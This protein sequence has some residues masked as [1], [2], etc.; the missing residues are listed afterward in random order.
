MNLKEF[1]KLYTNKDTNKNMII[2]DGVQL[3]LDTRK[4]RIFDNVLVIGGAGT[5]KTHNFIEPNILKGNCS[6]IIHDIEGSLYDET[7]DVLRSKGYDIQVLDFRKGMYNP[8][9]YIHSDEDVCDMI[10]CIMQNTNYMFK[11]NPFYYNL[12]VKFLSAIFF[13]LKETMSNNEESFESVFKIMNR[14]KDNYY[15]LIDTVNFMMEDLAKKNPNSLAVQ[16][17]HYFKAYC[18]MNNL[19][20]ILS[21][22][23]KR[24]SVFEYYRSELNNTQDIHLENIGNQ[25]TAIFVITPVCQDNPPVLTSLFFSQV[26][27]ELKHILFSKK[28]YEPFK[29]H[30]Q[31]MFDEFHNIGIIPKLLQKMN[32]VCWKHNVGYSFVIQ[33]LTQLQSM[34]EEDWEILIDY[35][36]NVLVFNPD[37][38]YLSYQSMI[39][40][41]TKKFPFETFNLSK[42]Y[43]CDCVYFLI[44][45]GVFCCN[46]YDE[47]KQ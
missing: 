41:F 47:N 34:Y 36:P 30:I 18:N 2:A 8:F 3:D 22:I 21:S 13:L 16:N 45:K 5:G 14:F 37:H 4:T 7:S 42:I 39:N 32:G 38:V 6:Y 35:C 28:P 11:K 40:Y 20:E 19:S 1:N 15:D 29:Y 46:K 9:Q 43:D 33:S 17:W 26:M 23:R 12:G 24:L 44:G 31:F 25:K 27:S 10:D